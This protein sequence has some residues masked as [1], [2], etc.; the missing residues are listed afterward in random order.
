MKFDM[1]SQ[2]HMITQVKTKDKETQNNTQV[3]TMATLLLITTHLQT[4]T[5]KTCVHSSLQAGSQ[6]KVLAKSL[7]NVIPAGGMRREMDQT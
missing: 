4:H 7:F 1:F 5:T 6:V 3:S 2:S